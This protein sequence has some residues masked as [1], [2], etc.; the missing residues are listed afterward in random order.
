MR[1][2]IHQINYFPWLGY[3]NKIAKSDTFI[4]LDEVQL[5][6]NNMMHRNRYLNKN[7]DVSYITI[8]FEKKGYMDK[9]FSEIQLKSNVKWQERQINALRDSYRLAPYR[10]EIIDFIA[11]IFT[12]SYE[13]LID[14]NMS[15]LN[16]ILNALEI[17]T[18]IVLQSEMV[19]DHSL[20]KDDLLIALLKNV[21]ANIYLSGNGARKYMD[22][23]DFHKEGIA[24]QFQTFS[25]F[26]YKQCNSIEHIS[27][28]SI[29]D[30]LFNCGIANTRD[31][32]WANM[33][34]HE[35]SE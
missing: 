34:E 12:Q 15:A 33:C 14:V 3:F 5:I 11:P 7:G 29:I 9:K 28:L 35:I 2:G 30:V 21:G 13:Y 23:E 20:K 1:V 26:E 8:A 19:Y 16:L 31:Y 32:F 17:K 22:L 4:L 10:K 6:D 25:P 24:V 27:G 18:K